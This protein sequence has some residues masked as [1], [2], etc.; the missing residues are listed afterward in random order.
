M[1]EVM[2]MAIIFAVLVLRIPSS[3]AHRV[4]GGA[5]FG[6]AHALRSL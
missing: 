2:A 1:A 6:L 3:M 4:A 5:Q